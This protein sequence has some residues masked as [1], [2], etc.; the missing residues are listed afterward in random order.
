[1]LKE[2]LQDTAYE[3]LEIM[4]RINHPEEYYKQAFISKGVDIT[5]LTHAEICLGIA[6]MKSIEADF[7]IWAAENMPPM[8]AEEMEAVTQSLIDKGFA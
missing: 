4:S 3:R 6:V 1:M 8:P 7:L 2:T 5:Q